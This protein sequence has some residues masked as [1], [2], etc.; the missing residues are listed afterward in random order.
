MKRAVRW[1][2]GCILLTG[3][4]SDSPSTRAQQGS[5]S[6]GSLPIVQ[7]EMPATGGHFYAM[8][9]YINILTKRM[10]SEREHAMNVERQKRLESDT[11]RLMG[12][13]TDLNREMQSDKELSPLDLSR[14]AAEIEKLAH[15]VQDRMKG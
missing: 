14:R 8:N 5:P 9:A 2:A 1:I 3:C 11:I 4:L 15:D 6:I 10:A 13:V 12:L 7:M